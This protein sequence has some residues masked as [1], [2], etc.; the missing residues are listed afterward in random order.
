MATAKGTEELVAPVGKFKCDW[1]SEP[2]ASNVEKYNHERSKHQEEFQARLIARTAVSE[3]AGATGYG[4]NR[5]PYED[6]RKVAGLHMIELAEYTKKFATALEAAAPTMGESRKQQL[7]LHFDENSSRYSQDPQLLDR[8]LLRAGMTAAQTEYVKLVMLPIDGAPSGSPG[9]NGA[10]GQP[11]AWT[12]NPSTGQMAP[13]IVMGGG[14]Q[15]PQQPNMP[16]IMMPPAQPQ[17]QSDPDRLTRY[18]LL[19]FVDKIADKLKTAPQEPQK[20]PDTP[21]RR[22]QQLI[23]NDEGSPVKDPATGA[24]LYSWVEEPVAM[25]KEGFS[26]TVDMLK[27]LG[28]VG[29]PAAPTADEIAAATV[30]AATPLI[31]PQNTG[32]SQE[33]IALE[34]KFDAVLANQ[35][36]DTAVNAAVERAGAQFATSMQPMLAELEKLRGTQGLSDH[37]AGLRHQESMQN[38]FLNGLTQTLGGLRSDLQPMFMTQMVAQFKA[39]GL[40]DSTI[41]DLVSRVGPTQTPVTED[42]TGAKADAMRKWVN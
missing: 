34:K 3:G 21:M 16:F 31:Q 39:L 23:V 12:Y 17:T 18:D 9:Y 14:Q 42:L 38:S 20:A 37:Q 19:D 8:F 40:A 4:P 6:T 1:C 13:I 33:Y 30:K 11:Q 29:Q 10:P 36:K 5:Q 35:E 24:V 32:P 7:I 27:T 28:V 15:Q 22:Y 26:Q 41:A 2:A 25:D